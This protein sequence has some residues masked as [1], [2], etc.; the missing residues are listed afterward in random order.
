MK[1][2]APADKALDFKLGNLQFK[3]P[4]GEVVDIPDRFVP[5]MKRM[6]VLLTEVVPG[7]A[8]K[9]E[10]EQA[11]KPAKAAEAAKSQKA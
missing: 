2:I 9:L 5:G 4:A 3:V 7:P 6:G 8:P 1:F 10:P 11:P